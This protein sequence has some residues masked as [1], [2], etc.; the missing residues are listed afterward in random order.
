MFARL[1]T[2]LTMGSRELPPKEISHS[3]FC[4]YVE[5]IAFILKRNPMGWVYGSKRKPP[6]LSPRDGELKMN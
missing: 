1:R 5:A 3:G 2:H 6:T 4:M